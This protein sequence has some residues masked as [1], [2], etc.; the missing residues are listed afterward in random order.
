MRIG[1]LDVGSNSAHLKIAHVAPG[2]PPRTVI[3]VKHRTKLAEAV[4]KDG[5]ISE[6][7]VDRVVT[8]IVDAVSY[9]EG[10]EPHVTLSLPLGA[11]RLTRQCLRGDPP[12]AGDVDNLK[13]HTREVI[14]ERTCDL[15]SRPAPVRVAVTSK[16]F[17]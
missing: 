6:K 8:A 7:A 12:D 2:G 15:R 14:R 11:G 5:S 1:V 3:S 4:E 16:T 13:S 10:H 9:G 17:K